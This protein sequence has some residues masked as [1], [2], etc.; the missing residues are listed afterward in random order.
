[1]MRSKDTCWL[2]LLTCLSLAWSIH[3]T[4]G[5]LGADAAPNFETGS[6]SVE[7]ETADGVFLRATYWSP[8]DANEET[9]V[10]MLLHMRG[11]N[12]RDCFPLAK[13]IYDGYKDESGK[14]KDRMAAITF[15]FRGHGESRQIDPT[16]YLDP[17]GRKPSGDSIDESSEFRKGV[18]LGRF[19]SI[20][21]DRVKEFLVKEN[22][23]KRLNISRLGIVACGPMSSVLAVNWAADPEYSSIQ[24]RDLH[25]LV[26]VSPDQ[27]YRD[28]RV[29]TKLDGSAAELP[30]FLISGSSR[31]NSAA[32]RLARSL[33]VREITPAKEE[34]KAEDSKPDRPSRDKRR[35][36]Y[37]PE[38]GWLQI[39]SNLVGTKLLNPPVEG[40]DRTIQNY[41]AFRLKGKVT[42]M[43]K[44]RE[45]KEEGFGG[46]RKFR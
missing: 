36:F 42:L 9:P 34:P 27:R 7:L 19:L 44:V 39:N 20:D 24:R 25:A 1:M 28:L 31:R 38:S 35:D 40:L 46:S 17:R 22:N 33:N 6:Q 45:T 16:K 15:D 32:Q 30:I 2:V 21:I 8:S 29:L 11:G 18:E 13:L 12:Q 43:W 41:L 14:A 23:A 3:W 10:I 4:T 37:R 5:A 26:L